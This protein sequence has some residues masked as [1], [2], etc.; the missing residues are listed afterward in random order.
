MPGVSAFTWDGLV[1]ERLSSRGLALLGSRWRGWGDGVHERAWARSE[2]LPLLRGWESPLGMGLWVWVCLSFPVSFVP[3]PHRW[4]RVSDAAW[5]RLTE[6]SQPAEQ[7]E[8]LG[9]PSGGREERVQ[10]HEPSPSGRSGSRKCPRRR[11]ASGE[12][13]GKQALWVSVLGRPRATWRRVRQE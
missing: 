3:W 12:K 2:G 9:S 4:P 11:E 7:G 13:T 5:R 8:D 6:R 10:V 1:P